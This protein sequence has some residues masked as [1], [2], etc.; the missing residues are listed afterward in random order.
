MANA[1]FEMHAFKTL[2]RL[3]ERGLS[4]GG[5]LRSIYLEARCNFCGYSE[6]KR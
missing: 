5:T 4:D 1:A 3:E 2:E 6:R